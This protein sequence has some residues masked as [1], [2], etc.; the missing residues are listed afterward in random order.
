MPR[1]SIYV[2]HLWTAVLV[3]PARVQHCDVTGLLGQ[4]VY[5][6]LVRR[7]G[8]AARDVLLAGVRG[9]RAKPSAPR[10]FPGPTQA[11]APQFP[12]TQPAAEERSVALGP[13]ASMAK[14]ETIRWLHLSDLHLGCPGQA[15]WWQAQHEFERGVRAGVERHGIPN[16]VLWTGDLTFSG[17]K[18]LVDGVGPTQPNV[19]IHV[20]FQNTVFSALRMPIS[21]PE[22]DP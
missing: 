17:D 20:C 2:G 10:P 11:M 4:V 21:C 13:T 15:L 8:A 22:W 6:D 5:I 16:L 1:V 9:E 19:L 7:D 3:V 14:G 18:P 12:G